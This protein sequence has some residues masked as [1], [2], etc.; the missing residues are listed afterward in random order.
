MHTQLDVTANRLTK[1]YTRVQNQHTSSPDG[2]HE[3]LTLRP[4]PKTVINYKP[5][6][7]SLTHPHLKA[8]M[9][10]STLLQS[11]TLLMAQ[12]HTNALSRASMSVQGGA[13]GL[14]TT[15]MAMIG[16]NST[17]SRASIT[18]QQEPRAMEIPQRRHCSTSRKTALI[19]FCASNSSK[20]STK[21]SE[22]TKR[23]RW[24]PAQI[25]C[26]STNSRCR[27]RVS[28]VRAL[29][30]VHHCQIVIVQARYMYNRTPYPPTGRG[31]I[32]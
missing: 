21:L 18:F 4:K 23:Q 11:S 30:V 27:C 16:T 31:L 26:S 20:T 9:K 2:R 17:M 10:C 15:V 12:Q 29:E 6:H 3:I 13:A 28:K 22:S 1:V 25:L 5:L 24:C 14:N 7:N 8:D 19:V 32:W